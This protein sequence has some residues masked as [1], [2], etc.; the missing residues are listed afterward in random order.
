[1]NGRLRPKRRLVDFI[2]KIMKCHGKLEGSTPKPLKGALTA[3]TILT[4]PS[5]KK[6][7]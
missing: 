1:M 2:L 3:N 4:Q 6:R 7:A 5:P